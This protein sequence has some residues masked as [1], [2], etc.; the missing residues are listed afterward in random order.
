[1]LRRD[2]A[3]RD[4]AAEAEGVADGEHP[5]ADAGLLGRELHER[6]VVA[7]LHLQERE[8]G[9]GIGADH[10]RIERAA[11]VHDDLHLGAVVDH[12]VVGHHIAVGGDEE[13]RTLA[14]AEAARLLAARIAGTSLAAVLTL[15]AVAEFAEE[16][17]QRMAFRQIRHG[18]LLAARAALAVRDILNLHAHGDDGGLHPVDHVGEGG[19][20]DGLRE[21]AQLGMGG[22]RGH[23]AGLDRA[24]GEK[25]R[26]RSGAEPTGATLA[27]GRRDRLRHGVF[28]PVEF[29]RIRQD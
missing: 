20:G 8:I 25:S 4:R 9:L 28:T 14:L 19:H 1:V 22:R 17:L 12:V 2:D 10:L 13:A 15:L 11:V 5:I 16:A 23:E 7:A 26:H 29:M 24:A 27:S 3:G 6:E 18:E 21:R